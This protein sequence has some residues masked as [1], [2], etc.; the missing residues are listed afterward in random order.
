METGSCRDPIA[1]S[2]TPFVPPSTS[3]STPSRCPASPPTSRPRTRRR[4]P[5]GTTSSRSKT[6][7]HRCGSE[8]VLLRHERVAANGGGLERSLAKRNGDD[9]G[10]PVAE[11]GFD[12]CL[13]AVAL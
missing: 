13:A 12:P 10:A 9:E 2:S 4:T 1:P 6:T 7:D 3:S 8:L 5:K 11:L